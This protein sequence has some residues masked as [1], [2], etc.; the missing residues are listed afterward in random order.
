MIADRIRDGYGE[1]EKLNCAEKILYASNEVYNLG[2]DKNALKLA[3]GF[4]G[5]M[6]TGDLCG[7]I[8]GSIMVLGTM[9]VKNNGHE[10]DKIKKLTQE[11][12]SRYKE[13]MGYIDCIPLKENHL[14]EQVKCR[15]IIVKAAEILDD[16]IERE[17]K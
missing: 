3:A 14:D 11:L 5:G 12:I 15:N 8:T 1:E 4:G 9:F 17:A 7:A 10:S 13:E 16:I 2:L 6:C